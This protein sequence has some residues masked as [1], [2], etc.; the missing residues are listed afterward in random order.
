MPCR[1]RSK[2]ENE[3]F[4][5]IEVMNNKDIE[6]KVE[7][8]FNTVLS[9]KKHLDEIEYLQRELNVTKDQIIA[10]WLYW[11]T[12]IRK[13]SN[14]VYSSEALR[15]VMHLHNYLVGSWHE[16]R[17]EIVLKYLKQIN[18]K[19]MC[20]IGFGVPQKYVKEFLN[21]DIVK[22]FLGDYEKTSLNFAEQLLAFWDKG[23]QRKINLAIF[24]MNT[25]SLPTGYD[26]YI[27]QDSIEHAI[28]PF[29]TLN[30]FV[31]S[32][33]KNTHFIFSLPI[34]IKNPIPE[35]NICW[36]DEQEIFDWLKKLGLE[37]VASDSI[38]MNKQV[39]IF[40]L[41]LH[42]DFREVVVLARKF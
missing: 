36:K 1:L 42:P 41:S 24:D 22:I 39:D 28:N 19:S 38:K 35:H 15:L 9:D 11:D 13:Y 5:K 17:Q 31:D 32:T 40:S 10:S 23:R 34:E 2:P 7:K 14:E 30:K 33:S 26:S 20:E 3:F 27:F 21:T 12:A 4:A 16:K 37:I 18:S 6:E 29:E 25:D 8:L